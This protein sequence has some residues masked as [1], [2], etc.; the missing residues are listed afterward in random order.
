MVG[1]LE[2]KGLIDIIIC[3][4]VCVVIILIDLMG[5]DVVKMFDVIKGVVLICI[6]F[7]MLEFCFLIII[8]YDKV[9]VEKLVV[10]L[11]LN[12]IDYVFEMFVVKFDVFVFFDVEFICMDFKE[13]EVDGIKFCVLVLEIIVLEILL[14]CK[15]SLME[16]Y[17][18]VKF[19]DGVDEVLLFVVDIFKEEVILLVLN[20]LVKI[21]VEKSFGVIVL[22]DIVVLSGIMSCKK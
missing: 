21:V 18:I 5:D 22:G 8:D 13:Y 12:I 1:G 14:N 19:E 3:L 11:G 4:L 20:D 17:V 15:D 7:D 6:L 9:V 10:D 2:I 16:I